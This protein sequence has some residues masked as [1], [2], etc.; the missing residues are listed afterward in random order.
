MATKDF[1]Y[2]VTIVLKPSGKKQTLLIIDKNS[3]AIRERCKN[4]VWKGWAKSFK[5]ERVKTFKV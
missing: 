3:K 1:L 2:K 5:I 4:R